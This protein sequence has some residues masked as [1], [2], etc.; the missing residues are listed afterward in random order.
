[1]PPAPATVVAADDLLD[2]TLW[3]QRAVEHDL[4]YLEVYRDAREKLAA[5]LADPGWDALPKDDR[6]GSPRGWRRR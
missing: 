5:A 1:M 2:A 6:E 4:V 3:T